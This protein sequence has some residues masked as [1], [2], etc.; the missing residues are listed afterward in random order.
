[1]DTV[2]YESQKLKWNL[3]FG[4]QNIFQWQKSFLNLD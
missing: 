1:M 2:C 3:L 4:V